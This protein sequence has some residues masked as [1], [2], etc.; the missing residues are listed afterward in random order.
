MLNFNYS[1]PTKIF[2]GKDQIKVLGKEIKKYG[3]K[4]LLAYGGGSI[5]KIGLYGEVIKILN[6]ENIP[7]W[8]LSGIEPNP[9]IESVREGIRICREN[10]I[11]FILPVG[12]GSTI[13]CAKVIAAGFFYEGDPWDLVI[14]KAKIE[15]V[16]PIASVLTLAATGS[17]MDAG[18]V[19]TNPETKQKLGVGHPD[20]APKFSILDPTYTFSVPASQTAAG[21]ADIMSHILESYFSNNKDAFVQDK[22]AEGLLKTCIKYGPIAIKEPDNYE[23]RAN[24]MWASSLAING[25]IR[26]GK[27]AIWSVH[28]LQHELGAYYD[29]THGVGLAILTPHWMRHVLSDST[30]EKF[31][32]YGK[33]VWDIKDDKYDYD[34][35]NEAIDKTQEFFKSLGIPTTLR[36]LGIGEENLEKMARAVTNYNGGTVGSYKPLSYED[37]LEIYKKAL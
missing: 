27:E 3:S 9:R 26:Y 35:A 17:E 28:P 7:F 36:E 5:K 16:L 25:L 23:A 37:V 8:E 19:I 30:V 20:M 29:I 18:A 24:L 11:D 2:F 32:E 4:V 21:T 12:G 14:R 10:D 6:E 33:N 34:I 1:I 31:V 15:K 13:D 22:I